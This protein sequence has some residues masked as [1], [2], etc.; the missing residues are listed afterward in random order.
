MDR[1]RS[2]SACESRFRFWTNG[3]RQ[4]D[5]SRPAMEDCSAQS[6]MRREKSRHRGLVRPL[7]RFLIHDL[8]CM[9]FPSKNR[10]FTF[11]NPLKVLVRTQGCHGTGNEINFLEQLEVVISL[12]HVRRG[13]IRIFLE[14]PMGMFHG[15]QGI[16]DFANFIYPKWRHVYQ[17]YLSVYSHLGTRTLI[18]PRRDS[19]LSGDG[20]TNW[21]FLSVHNWGEN[22]VGTWTLTIETHVS[23]RRS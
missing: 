13:S 14:S 2:W 15:R 5:Q 4:I 23:G 16:V 1:E 19:D 6:Q 9:C 22:P 12:S 8:N 20:L 7:P 10:L 3:R 11:G 18:A 17:S 21:P